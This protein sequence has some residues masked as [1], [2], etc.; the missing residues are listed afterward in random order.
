M[1]ESLLIDFKD[2]S[3]FCMDDGFRDPKIG[4]VCRALRDQIKSRKEQERGFPRLRA[5]IAAFIAA[6]PDE[7]RQQLTAVLLPEKV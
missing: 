1:S 2:G 3:T 6:Q 7:Y 5:K 4:P